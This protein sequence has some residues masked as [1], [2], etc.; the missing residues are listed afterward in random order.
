MGDPQ[1][2]SRS[3]VAK[4]YGWAMRIFTV[5]LEMVCPPVFGIW[6]DRRLGSVAAF[7][8]I[9][10]GLGLYLGMWHLLRMT[11]RNGNSSPVPPKKRR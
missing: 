10:A 7:T 2:D 11:S 9:G 4:A 3:L 8:L 6:L 1:P 5:A